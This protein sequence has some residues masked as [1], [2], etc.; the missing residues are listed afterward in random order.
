M[1]KDIT[2]IIPYNMYLLGCKVEVGKSTSDAI[3]E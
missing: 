2:L 1:Y 3:I